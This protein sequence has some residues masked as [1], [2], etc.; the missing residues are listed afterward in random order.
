MGRVIAL[1]NP[2]NP[3]KSR[4]LA[5]T[6]NVKP[7]SGFS[8][9]AKSENTDRKRNFY[10]ELRCVQWMPLEF[11]YRDILLG[12]QRRFQVASGYG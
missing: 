1:L 11:Q 2:D 5:P 10:G 6:E 9:D 12:F 7:L 4:E 3:V 8:D